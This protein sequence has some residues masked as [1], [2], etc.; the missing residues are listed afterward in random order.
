MK[1]I[2][3]ICAFIGLS[4]CGCKESDEDILKKAEK[5]K[6]QR[7]IEANNPIKIKEQITLKTQFSNTISEGSDLLTIFEFDGCE[8]I[9]YEKYI[10]TRWGTMGIAHKGNCIK[11]LKKK[12]E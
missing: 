7:L 6:E 9:C 2:M 4:L 8:Y 5:I 3:I 12:N 10:G 11:C 1:N